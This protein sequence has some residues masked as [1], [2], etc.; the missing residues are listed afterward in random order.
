VYCNYVSL[1]K[2]QFVVTYTICQPE[3]PTLQGSWFTGTPSVKMLCPQKNCL[4]LCLCK[5]IL[6]YWGLVNVFLSPLKLCIGGLQ[7]TAVSWVI[8][9]IYAL[10]LV[11]EFLSHNCAERE[12]GS[13]DT[14]CITVFLFPVLSMIMF[15]KDCY[16]CWLYVNNVVSCGSLK[17]LFTIKVCEI[18]TTDY[19]LWK[20]AW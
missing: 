4:P 9:K 18:C 16:F 15:L 17:M 11:S 1:V 14:F 19:C 5:N 10:Y 2:R 13:F 8:W 20:T 6:V 3:F 12:D 7:Q